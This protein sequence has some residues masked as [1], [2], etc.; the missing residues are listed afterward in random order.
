M[1]DVLYGLHELLLL[2][3]SS[4]YFLNCSIYFLFIKYAQN[5]LTVCVSWTCY[6]IVCLW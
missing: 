5:G 6:V 2:P 4:S 3:K 1:R